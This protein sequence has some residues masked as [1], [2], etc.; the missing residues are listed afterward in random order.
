MGP[1]PEVKLADAPKIMKCN[2]GVSFP[3]EVG[4]YTLT[5]ADGMMKIAGG[6][7][8]GATQEI[9]G[10]DVTPEVAARWNKKG[11]MTDVGFG[12]LYGMLGVQLPPPPKQKE[13]DRTVHSSKFFIV[14]HTF[15]AGKGQQW[16]GQVAEL[17]AD[18]AKMGE[19]VKKQNAAGFHGHTFM[20]KNGGTEDDII[21]LWEAK[22]G[23]T[24][25]QFQDF[26]DG[27]L[28]PTMGMMNN[29]CYEI[30][31]KLTGGVGP[32]EPKFEQLAPK[33]KKK[34]SF[35][36]FKSC[37]TKNHDQVIVGSSPRATDKSK[38]VNNNT[39]QT[40]TQANYQPS[41]P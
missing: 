29:H 27:E 35:S 6:T 4:I 22:H 16:W 41:S 28:S 12:A 38:V 31:M 24:A 39:E 40:E 23:C 26:I 3:V 11:D 10:V 32:K 5:E 33:L 1:F 14:H 13:E 30:D 17:F 36:L 21:C 2:N 19:M 8:A 7:Y 25:Q 9:S 20:P 37:K 15:M 18:E 34:K